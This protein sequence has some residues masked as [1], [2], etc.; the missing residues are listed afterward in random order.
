MSG[1]AAFYDAADE[2]QIDSVDPFLEEVAA[3]VARRLRSYRD[4]VWPYDNNRS[5]TRRGLPHSRPNWS[6]DGTTI[7][8]LT[9]HKGRAYASYVHGGLYETL[10]PRLIEET[11][12]SP[13]AQ[14]VLNQALPFTES[15]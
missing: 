11:L 13:E 15:A 8:N 3:T 7:Q 9:A 10:I 5:R 14:A 1:A 6:A 2:L 4:P 12:Q